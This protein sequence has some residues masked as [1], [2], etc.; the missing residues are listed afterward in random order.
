MGKRQAPYGHNMQGA[1]AQ[2]PYEARK[3]FTK[4]LPSYINTYRLW[5]RHTPSQAHA[6]T[7]VLLPPQGHGMSGNGSNSGSNSRF[8]T[9]N[10]IDSKTLPH[11]ATKEHTMSNAAKYNNQGCYEQSTSLIHRTAGIATHAVH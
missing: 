9:D 8:T 1:C 11:H 10:F 4:S 6:F 3:G 2:T 5:H 7:G